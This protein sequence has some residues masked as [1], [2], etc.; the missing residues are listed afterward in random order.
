MRKTFK[1]MKTNQSKYSSTIIK[2]YSFDLVRNS[3]RNIVFEIIYLTNICIT[4]S[5]KK[6]NFAGKH[7]A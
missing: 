2:S 1:S 3:D 4:L 5:S 7:Y 6:L